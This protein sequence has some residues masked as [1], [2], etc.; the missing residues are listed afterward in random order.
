[1]SMRHRLSFLGAL[2]VAGVLALGVAGVLATGC[3]PATVRPTSYPDPEVPCPGGRTAWNLLI[4]DDRAEKI[5]SER[6]IHDVRDGIQKSFPGCQWKNEPEGGG[7]TITIEIHRLASRYSDGDWDAAAEWDVTVKSAQGGTL[8]HFEA[9]EEASSPNYS[10]RDNEKE[11]LSDAF[12][13]AIE[14][15]AKGLRGVSA[16][17]NRRPRV[18]TPAAPTSDGSAEARFANYRAARELA[19]PRIASRA[20][21][22]WNGTR[23]GDIAEVL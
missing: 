8:T 19:A 23:S 22:S 12:R 5:A 21:G 18:G 7:D 13:K 16:V 4:I 10:N 17:E 2:G 11:T 15:T 20:A 6:M 14:K 9:N 3:G 1:M